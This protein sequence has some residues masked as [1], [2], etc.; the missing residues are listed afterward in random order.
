MTDAT[1]RRQLSQVEEDMDDREQHVWATGRGAAG[2]RRPVGG[3]VRRA[4]PR[5]R[6]DAAD[7][8]PPRVITTTNNQPQV[9]YAPSNLQFTKDVVR[10]LYWSDN[11][12]N[13]TRFE[14]VI[15]GKEWVGPYPGQWLDVPSVTVQVPAN[16][17]SYVVMVYVPHITQFKVR[18]C[19]G[20][21][22]SSWAVRAVTSD[23]PYSL[24]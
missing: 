13:E 9:V 12:S 10:T 22:C 18:A 3:A 21:V 19:N 4:R 23:G 24:D 15:S 2:G 8:F 11:S 17:T 1:G 6:L 20:A 16:F 5:R 14:V 7:Q